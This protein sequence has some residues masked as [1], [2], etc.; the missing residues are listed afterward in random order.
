MDKLWRW[1]EKSY[2]Q[3]KKREI[4]WTAAVI[5]WLVALWVT[6]WVE[7][8]LYGEIISTGTFSYL[9]CS[10]G[11]VIGMLL[12]SGE[13]K[14]KMMK[15]RRWVANILKAICWIAICWAVV[16]RRLFVFA[17]QFICV[18]PA[19]YWL[20]HQRVNANEDSIDKIS[21]SACNVLVIAVMLVVGTLAGPRIMGMISTKQAEKAIAEQGFSEA[22]YLGW[23]YGRWVYRDAVDKSFYEEEMQEEKYYMVFGRKEGEPYRFVIDPKGGEI[24]IAATEAAEP[25]LGNWYRSREGGV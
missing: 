24:I 16:D 17:V 14:P 20:D 7:H 1:E 2:Q 11:I 25:E 15:A 5:S 19:A 10:I 12:R 13:E 21:M 18:F 3:N 8:T 22:E 9:G 4:L 6:Y 23:L